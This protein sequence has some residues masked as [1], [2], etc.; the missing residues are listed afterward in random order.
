MSNQ[1]RA[2]LYVEGLDARITPSGFNGLN[3]AAAHF[4]PVDPCMTAS[5]VFALNYGT[6]DAGAVHGLAGLNVAVE[7]HIPT[8]PCMTASP[9]FVGLSGGSVDT[10]A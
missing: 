8:D 3:V 2:R 10:P 9:V 4:T 7:Q 5:P 1:F 6:V